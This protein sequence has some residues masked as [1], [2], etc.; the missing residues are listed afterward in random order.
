[1]ADS[2]KQ[3]PDFTL[4]HI[5]GMQVSSSEYRGRN[6]ILAFGGRKTAGEVERLVEEVR[7]RHGAEEVPI[8]QIVT[9]KGVPRL[10][11]SLA[12][13]DVKNGYEKQVEREA[14]RLRELGQAAS[15]DP[16][17][18]VIILLDW[19]GQLV[20]SLG[21]KGLE[22]ASVALLVDGQGAIRGTGT[23]EKAGEQILGLLS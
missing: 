15:A 2:A 6:Y 21:I 9:L 19:E 22:S 5:E 20:G 7:A 3:L 10:V 11:H 18:S 1:M 13:K 23:G 12:R 16:A 14:E 8:V 17:R 4:P